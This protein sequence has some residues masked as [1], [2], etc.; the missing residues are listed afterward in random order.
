MLLTNLK[1]VL[2]SVFCVKVCWNILFQRGS[3][4][5]GKVVFRY[6]QGSNIL[7]LI[8]FEFCPEILRIF[9]KILFFL[10]L[11]YFFQNC[12]EL[13]FLFCY[14]DIA[15]QTNILQYF[16]HTASVDKQLRAMEFHFHSSMEYFLPK[17]LRSLSLYN[18]GL[19]QDLNMGPKFSENSILLESGGTLCYQQKLSNTIKRSQ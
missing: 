13:K 3:F 18:L 2:T 8:I 12:S 14:A 5:E 6:F 4:V 10:D 11:E 19:G 17:M 1:H 7:F 16:N 9:W 15:L